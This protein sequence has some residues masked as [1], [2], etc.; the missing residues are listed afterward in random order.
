MASRDLF[1]SVSAAQSVAPQTV[2]SNTTLTGS[3]IDTNGYESLTILGIVGGRTDGT[4]AFKVQ[5]CD[6]SGGT[7]ADVDATCYMAGAAPAG[8]TAAGVLAVGMKDNAAAA[9]TVAGQL[10]RF[11]KV[12]ITSTSVTTGATGVGAL[13]LLGHP[14]HRSPAV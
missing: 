3:A 9:P 13:V 12:I 14:K 10:R 2:A 4:Y 8:V 5:D 6:T 1:H 11:V 7:Y